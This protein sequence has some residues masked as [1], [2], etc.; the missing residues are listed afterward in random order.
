MTSR[1]TQDGRTL[2][3]ST[4]LGPDRLLIRRLRGSEAMGALYCYEL[5]LMSEGA[6]VDPQRLLGQPVSV[7]IHLPD[8]AMRE[9]NGILS[10]MALADRHDRAENGF[11]QGYRATLHP[12]FWRLTLYAHCRF[13]HDMSVPDILRQVL[14]AHH[15][16][17]ENRCQQ[18]YPRLEHCAQYNETD[19]A[20]CCRLMEREGIYFFFRHAGGKESLVLADAAGAHQELPHAKTLAFDLRPG[21]GAVANWMATHQ[22]V[23][24]ESTLNAYD[25]RKVTHSLNQGLLARS[26]QPEGESGPWQRHHDAYA[27]P[28]TGRHYADVEL[29]ARRMPAREI[30]ADSNALGVT[31]GGCF[32][33]QGHPADSQNRRYLVTRAEYCIDNPAYSSTD[34]P[35]S[36]GPQCRLRA[37]PADQPFRMPVETPVP[38]AV[39]PQTAVVVG[40]ADGAI[41]TDEYGRIQV[42][43][44]WEQ[45]APPDEAARQ[46][47]CWVRV[48]Q[49]WAGKGWGS[50]F[51]PRAGQEVMVEFINGDIDR[52]LVTGSL[53]NAANPPP[54]ALP[55]RGDIATLH[56]RSTSGQG[57]NEVRFIDA[58]GKEQLFLHAEKDLKHYVKNDALGWVGRDRHCVTEGEARLLTGKDRHESVAGALRQRIDKD[59]HLSIGGEARVETGGDS[60]LDV[61]G[62]RRERIGGHLG[63]RCEGQ[64]DV[65]AGGTYALQGARVALSAETDMVLQAPRITLKAG[66]SFITLGPEGVSISGPLVKLNSG[67]SPGSAARAA[68]PAPSAPDRPQAP[69]PSARDNGAREAE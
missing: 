14:D 47:R 37:I 69:L 18:H 57:F 40:P 44:H 19:F 17:F 62:T 23:G 15:V 5:E 54:Y 65:R 45:F 36:A 4:P 66:A 7:R 30:R 2:E 48:A 55:R 43:F 35:A 60:G 10:R 68:P 12:Q 49:G 26:R 41:H 46:R 39:G 25:F 32:C 59:H 51:L 6:R 50:F 22:L 29:E 24:S 56:S 13:F 3:L 67:G 8:G 27:D 64:V 31:A 63:L 28:D 11:Y 1:A 34:E 16:P 20:F 21:P 38:R 58:A 33:L 52:P 9:I 61:R 42:Q 53:Y